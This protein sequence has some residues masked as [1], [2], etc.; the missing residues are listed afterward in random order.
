MQETDPPNATVPEHLQATIESIADLHADHYLS[1]PSSQIGIEW[2]TARLGRPWP[3]FVV[4]ALIVFWILFN[5]LAVPH[6]GRAID[7]P[8]FFWLQGTGTL[9][10]LLMTFLILTTANRQNALDERRAQL[11]LQ[12]ALL[13]EAKITKVIELVERIRQEHP[14]LSNPSEEETGAM[15]TPADP[16][17]VLNTMDKAHRHAL[18]EEAR[19][20]LE[21][22]TGL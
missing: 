4:F 8:P 14:L 15:T 12:I 3:V 6:G 2:L 7:P 18:T 9:S 10:A 1:L 17:A 13:T 22:P 16:K 21:R 5:T 20:P 19:D 11:T